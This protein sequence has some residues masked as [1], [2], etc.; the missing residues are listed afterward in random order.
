[1]AP[2]NRQQEKKKENLFKVAE[3]VLIFQQPMKRDHKLSTNWRGPFPIINIENPFR[4]CYDDR[5]RE[6]I[7][8][9]RHC[10]KF[11]TP[12]TSGKE[13]YV[14]SSDDTTSNDSWT[15]Q[16]ERSTDVGKEG[17]S[18]TP[19]GGRVIGS[20]TDKIQKKKKKDKNFKRHS[21]PRRC[22]KMLL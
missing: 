15:P 3:L 8:H 7:A 16:G 12:M 11:N 13:N 10:K 20:T 9:V 18:L 4:G 19:N 22:R 6:K 5:G 2:F 17:D 1:M 21:V 14:I